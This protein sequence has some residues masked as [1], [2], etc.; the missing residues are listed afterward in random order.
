MD[1]QLPCVRQAMDTERQFLSLALCKEYAC[2]LF[3]EI[4]PKEFFYRE[5]A[6]L[7][8]VMKRMHG[9]KKTISMTTV[10]NELSSAEEQ[11]MFVAMFD[12]H[13]YA[14]PDTLLRQFKEAHRAVFMYERV[15]H[16]KD[17]LEKNNPSFEGYFHETYDYYTCAKVT[18]ELVSMR[19][20]ADYDIE[21]LYGLL[22][23]RKTGIASIDKAIDAVY[24]GQF[25]LIAGS[26]G[27]GKTEVGLTIAYNMPDSLF[28]SLEMDAVELFIRQLA[29]F[30]GVN[31]RKIRKK[32]LDDVEVEKIRRA[33]EKI[34]NVST[35]K[36]NDKISNIDEIISLIRQTV[37]RDNIKQVVIDYLQLT[38][39]SYGGNQNER[40]EHISRRIKNLCR[41]L[42]VPIFG[43]SQLTKESIRENRAP[44][45]SDVRGSL[46]FTQDADLVMF[47][48]A[49]D[50]EVSSCSVGK[51]RNGEVGK[52][53]DFRYIKPIHTIL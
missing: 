12:P 31:S 3:I 36:I 4:N 51:Y 49:D 8:E 2:E 39:S 42:R 13:I 11:K 29:R 24:D 16:M 53:T 19:D 21:D 23:P 6:I 41:E 30:S 10:Y 44:I 9:S 34:K 50:D 32:S 27:C 20:L 28:V 17:M 46:A 26:P 15:M 14:D 5:V 48:Y 45:L 35:L 43:L 37:K 1:K 22:N 40:F 47:V 25:I 7:Q 52:I 33:K 38:E 18:N